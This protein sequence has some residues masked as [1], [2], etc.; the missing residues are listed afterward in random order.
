[1]NF[2]SSFDFRNGKYNPEMYFE[3]SVREENR[4]LGVIFVKNYLRERSRK[5]R[6]SYIGV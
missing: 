5:K 6:I 4:T 3:F 1:M 2:F